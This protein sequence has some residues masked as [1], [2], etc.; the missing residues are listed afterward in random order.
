[1]KLTGVSLTASNK[2]FTIF[3]ARPVHTCASDWIWASSAAQQ[4]AHHMTVKWPDMS[5]FSLQ[6]GK[7]PAFSIAIIAQLTKGN[8]TSLTSLSLGDCGLS[9]QGVSLLIQ[10]NWPALKTL[11]LTQNC[12]DAEAMALLAKGNWPLLSNLQLCYNPI[13][14][15]VAI[16]HLSAATWSLRDLGLSYTPVSAAMAIELAKLQQLCNLTKTCLENTG[17]TAASMSELS[18]ADWPLLGHFDISR[19]DLDAAA[20]HHLGMMCV[21][22]LE[23]LALAWANI[24]SQGA[25]WLAQV[26]RPLLKSLDLSYNELDAEAARHIASGCTHVGRCWRSCCWQ[27]THLDTMDGNT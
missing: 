26:S 19:N 18:R 15:T 24:T 3:T 9:A 7:L 10:G 25:Y 11:H 14:N 6:N 4:L 1:M 23:V 20:L 8:W 17:M 2:N 16:R 22:Q 27:E 5:S 21:P 13:L 12:L